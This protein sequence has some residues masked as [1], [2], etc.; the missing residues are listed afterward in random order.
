MMV[1]IASACELMASW[2]VTVGTHWS[3]RVTATAWSQVNFS[4]NCVHS[5]G[6]MQIPSCSKLQTAPFLNFCNMNNWISSSVI[7]IFRVFDVEHTLPLSVFL[8][9]LHHWYHSCLVFCPQCTARQ[10]IMAPLLFTREMNNVVSN[11]LRNNLR[12]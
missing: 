6:L 5:I 1:F 3:Y 4:F 11:L 7:D 2:C 10:M 8:W 9:R 12:A